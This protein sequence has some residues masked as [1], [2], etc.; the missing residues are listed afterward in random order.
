MIAATRPAL[1]VRAR[2]LY[3]AIAGFVAFGC[4]AGDP[5]YAVAF[6]NETDTALV[7]RVDRSPDSN[8]AVGAWLLPPRSAGWV[9]NAIGMVREAPPI[10]YVIVDES[11]CREV[12]VQRVDFSLAPDPNWTE[13]LITVSA[14]G[15][16]R[17]DASPTA[18]GE[19]NGDLRGTSL[20]PVT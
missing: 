20:C 12:A 15:R 2:M 7:I 13:F 16:T 11:S 17:L 10:D 5:G 1:P 4:G 18:A 19:I 14:D 6:R 8:D 3:L 9:L